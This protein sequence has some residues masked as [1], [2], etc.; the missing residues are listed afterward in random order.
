MRRKNDILTGLVISLTLS[1]LAM[2]ALTGYMITHPRIVVKTEMLVVTPT[3]NPNA[4]HVVGYTVK[5]LPLEFEQLI[6]K[7]LY[8]ST[9]S[10]SPHYVVVDYALHKE[11]YTIDVRLVATRFEHINKKN[12]FDR[13]ISVDEIPKIDWIGSVEINIQALTV[14]LIDVGKQ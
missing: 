1:S 6:N 11:Q 13:I 3:A 14:Y 2:A 8:I 10:S 9:P 7:W 4:P 5:P 12:I